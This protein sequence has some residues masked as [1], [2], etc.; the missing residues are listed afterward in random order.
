M[1]DA[2]GHSSVEGK[3]ILITGATS[4]IGNGIA[5]LCIARGAEVT[6]TSRRE[7]SNDY[8][9]KDN[10]PH[11]LFVGDLT[12]EDFIEEL[13]SNCG[14]LDGCV[15]SAG[16]T[17]IAP[18]LMTDIKLFYEILEINLIS[19]Y[20]LLQKLIKKKKMKDKS[21]V[22][23]ISSVEGNTKFTQGSSAYA[24]TKASISALTKVLAR[25]LSTKKIRVN[26]INPGIIDTP[27]TSN[28]ILPKEFFDSLVS[29]NPIPRYGEPVDIANAALF[30]LSDS[31]SW[32]TG[33]SITIDGGYSAV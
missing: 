10:V 11:P 14:D 25:E 12:S 27:M 29:K 20:S 13:S 23:F 31:S 17:L 26:C 2:A 33:T 15:L 28:S 9:S 4:G 24:C 8:L 22:V 32:I 7:F 30:L 19:Q 3:R 1:N 21:S 5:R 16:K 6:W 18:F